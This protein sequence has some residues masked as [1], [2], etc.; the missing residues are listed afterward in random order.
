[1][2]NFAVVGIGNYAENYIKIMQKLEK[3]KIAN[4]FCVVVRDRDKYPTAVN[5]LDDEGVVI[6]PSYDKMLSY[7]KQRVDIV[8]LP[9]ASKD[10][11]EYTKMALENGYDVIVERPVAITIQEVDQLLETQKQTERYCIV[12]NEFLYSSS[13]NLLC[14]EIS[15][16]RL[17][18]IKMIRAICGWPCNEAYFKRN[19]WAGHLITDQKWNL[20]GPATNHGASVLINALHL[21]LTTCDKT[22]QIEAVQAELYR[23]YQISSYD[24]VCMRIHLTNGS[25]VFFVASYAIDKPID[26][27]MQIECENALVNWNFQDEK[28]IIRFHSG[29]KKIFRERAVEQKYELVFR[30]A[31]TVSTTRSRN[32]RST[33]ESARS[34]VLALNLAFE[35]AQEILTIPPE[36]IGLSVSKNDQKIFVKDMESILT[37][38]YQEGKLFSELNVPWAKATAACKSKDYQT[39]P[40]NE[41]I[42]K[43][44]QSE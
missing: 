21:V 5:T 19:N 18:K 1:M 14:N 4:L 28:T 25:Q 11:F 17:G 36:F 44:M 23:A 29:R 24:T 43:W 12:G 7:G 39:F 27:A 30:E 8:A 41:K 35:S 38:S 34:H 13:I 31:I 33:I 10:H 40:Q 20:D 16:G 37:Q 3:E 22:A 15:S 32:P 6:Y 26:A 9:I 42:K 2:K